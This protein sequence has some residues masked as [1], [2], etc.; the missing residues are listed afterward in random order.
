MRY[1]HIEAGHAYTPAVMTCFAA[2]R[3]TVRRWAPDL[4]VEGFGAPRST[5]GLPALVPRPVVGVVQWLSAKEEAHHYHPPFATAEKAGLRAHRTFVAFSDDLA[6][7]LSQRAP[8][9]AVHAIPN[10]LPPEAFTTP[11]PAIRSHVAYLGHL[12]DAQK[13]VTLLMHAYAGSVA[14]GVTQQLHIAGA[15]PDEAMLRDLARRLGITDRVQFLGHMPVLDRFAG[16]T[17][18]AAAARQAQVYREALRR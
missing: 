18:D 4:V 16:L 17:W 2:Q 7:Q 12:E 9:A 14:A 8:R 3:R 1:L 13:G 15:G 10:G 11:E 6:A 5:W